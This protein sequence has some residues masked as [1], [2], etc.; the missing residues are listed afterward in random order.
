M[1]SRKSSRR[2]RNAAK[3]INNR[4]QIN[5]R[6]RRIKQK[7]VGRLGSGRVGRRTKGKRRDVVV[8]RLRDNY[9]IQPLNFCGN[10]AL[11]RK[12][13]VAARKTVISIPPPRFFSP[14]SLSL[15]FSFFFF[16]VATLLH[17]FSLPDFCIA[18]ATRTPR[19]ITPSA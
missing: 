17:R 14:L 7:K 15:S 4:W 10:A 3:L 19:P 9:A 2:A 13:V 18:K 5:Y 6:W 1:R 8:N 16:S 12:L 11:P